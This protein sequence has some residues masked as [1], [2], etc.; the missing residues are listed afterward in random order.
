MQVTRLH[1]KLRCEVYGNAFKTELPSLENVKVPSTA[2]EKV[3]ASPDKEVVSPDK[4]VV[5]PDNESETVKEIIEL[6]DGNSGSEDDG[7]L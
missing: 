7:Y 5:S 6:D 3:V 4:E 1:N 2:K